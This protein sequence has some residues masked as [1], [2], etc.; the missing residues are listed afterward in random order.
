MKDLK[1]LDQPALQKTAE[2]LAVL[3]QSAAPKLG[4]KA[5][6]LGG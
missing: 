4:L 6:T 2:E 5:P 3:L 1:Q